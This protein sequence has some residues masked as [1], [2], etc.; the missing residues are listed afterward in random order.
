MDLKFL[1][2]KE[3]KK[4][5]IDLC[6][7]MEYENFNDLREFYQ[8]RIYEKAT[9]EFEE[10]DLDKRLDPRLTMEN[11]KSIIVVAMS[12]KHNQVRPREYDEGVLSKSSYGCDYH[13]VLRDKLEKLAKR[14]SAYIEFEYK[15]FVD[16]GPLID[17]ELAFR[18][19]LGHFGK[20][21]SI[22][23]DEYGSY[24]FIAYILTDLDLEGDPMVEKTCGECSLCV[25]HC[26]GGAL[27]G[28]YTM[29]SR[30]CISYISQKKGLISEDERDK[31]G[32]RIYGCDLCQDICPK[33]KNLKLVYHEEFLPKITGG[34]L[35]PE[36]LLH[37]S[38]REFK[39]KY[40]KM[41]GSWRGKK[42]LLRNGIINLGNGRDKRN[43]KFL[44]SIK[45]EENEDLKTYIKWSIDKIE[46]NID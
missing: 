30:K 44:K 28:D 4:L 25:D 33:N 10:L 32:L 15:Y 5:G 38:N 34:Y 42:I 11:C 18:S 12:Y 22:I 6:G 45:L 40:G 7:I 27:N 8:I 17:R 24:I 35:R 36:E 31:L 9:S 23:N 19:G 20:N 29:D 41:S 43:L 14:L 1:I 46:N 16:T 2:K 37:M 26:P 21:C 3:A 39:S 13:L